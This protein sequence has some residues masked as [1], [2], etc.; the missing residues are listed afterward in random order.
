MSVELRIVEKGFTAA[1]ADLKRSLNGY[2]RHSQRIKIGCTTDPHA[3]WRRHA[4]DGWERMVLLW[5]ALGPDWAA[6]MEQSL[7]EHMHSTGFLLERANIAPGG[8]GILQD[9]SEHF[10]YVLLVRR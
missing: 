3:R 10:I 5:K 6:R 2:M 4:P 1:L 7:I 8:E 9:R